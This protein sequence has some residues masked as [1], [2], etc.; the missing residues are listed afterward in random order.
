M[1][2]VSVVIPIYKPDMEI[3]EKVRKSLK[4]QIVKPEIIEM[5]NNPEAV[6][7]NKG[8]KKA[9]GK[10]VVTH[11]QDYIPENKYWLEKLIK[12]LE[13][14]GVIAGNSYLYIPKW[15]W[16]KYPFLT[17]ILTINERIRESGKRDFA[18]WKKD[19]IKFGGFNENPKVIAMDSELGE[20]LE[21]AGEIVNPN[22]A[23]EHLHP[24]DN[25]K[26]IILNIRYAEARGKLFKE[27]IMKKHSWKAV[28]RAIPVLGFLPILYVFPW[29]RF[30]EYW[31]WLIP[32][33]FLAPLQHIIYLY[34]FWKGFLFNKESMRN[35]EVL[36]KK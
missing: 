1:V 5:W 14:E 7:I 35:K 2:N 19:F 21:K 11:A 36:Y 28:L 3:L 32:Y 17:K 9:K 27:G 8:V 22:V 30:K 26:K 13:N 29:K 10:I 6:S 12:P 18:Y 4:E 31:G 33:L 15:Y 16:R 25:N 23:V 24:L 34:G 20:K